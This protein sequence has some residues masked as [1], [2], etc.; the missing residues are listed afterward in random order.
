MQNTKRS[1]NG[2]RVIRTFISVSST[3]MYHFEHL[4]AANVNQDVNQVA[5]RNESAHASSSTHAQLK[6]I[7]IFIKA[8]QGLGSI[9]P[10]HYAS[11]PL[12]NTYQRTVTSSHKP[13]KA[14]KQCGTFCTQ[15][16]PSNIINREGERLAELS[17]L[18]YLY[19]NW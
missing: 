13:L 7:Q 11:D 4:K 18:L 8:I 3:I 5:T 16:K 19:Y 17:V 1:K 12:G 14:Y 6:Q 9:K 15:L 2:F 10:Y